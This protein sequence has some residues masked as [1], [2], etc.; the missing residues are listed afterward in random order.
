MLDRPL[1][2]R[3]WKELSADKSLVLLSGPRQC[4]KTTLARLIAQE[5]SNSAYFNW[6]IITDKRRLIREPYF[7]QDIER[8]DPSTPLVVLDEIHKYK[9]WKNYLKGISDGFGDRFLFLVTGSGRL[10]LYQRGGDSL[11]GR[12]NAFRLWPF[13]LGELH[14]EQTS[15]ARFLKDPLRLPGSDEAACRASLATLMAFSGF[16]EPYLA[17][18]PTT[19]RRWTRNYHRQLIREDVRDLTAIRN[20]DDVEILFHLLPSKVGSPLSLPS[21]AGDLKVTYNT[22]KGWLEVLER[23]YLTFSLT[24]W[25]ARVSR[26][27]HKER[28]TYLFEFA[29]IEDPAVRFENLVALELHR[30]VANWNDL[31]AGDFGLHF[32]RTK[33]GREVDFLISQKRQPILLVEAKYR[34]D[35]PAANLMRFQRELKVP[36]VQLLEAG[37]RYREI[38]HGGQ[39][40]LVA[41]AARWL[42]GL[43]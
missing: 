2:R 17:A 25:A 29:Q 1:Y 34:D 22:V 37:Q 30:A 38:E 41:P 36:A 35:A 32:V 33:E 21:L 31:G 9:Q 39:R 14:G 10:D 6:D 20:I 26:S 5:F 16:P 13:T 40:L 28:K 42:P 7:F 24:P 12:Y 4:G 8:R 11:A 15:L 18:R 43:P 23:F 27:L 3:V 19:Y